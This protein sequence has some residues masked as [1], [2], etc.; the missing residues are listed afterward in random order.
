MVG[1]L[2]QFMHAPQEI[3]WQ[4]AL[5]VLAYL[6]HAPRRGLLYLQHDQLC[7]EAYTNSSYAS[8]S[9]DKKSITM[10]YTHLLWCMLPLRF[11]G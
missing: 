8:D 11:F 2:S 7:V 9:G 5:C 1:L 3:Y 10:Y 4:A 6:K